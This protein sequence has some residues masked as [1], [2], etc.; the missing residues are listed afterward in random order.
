MAVYDDDFNSSDIEI[1]DVHN[2]YTSLGQDSISKLV[3]NSTKHRIT[4]KV[5]VKTLQYISGAEPTI[6][7][8][9][10]WANRFRDFCKSTL[11]HRYVYAFSREASY[12]TVK[13]RC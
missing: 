9:N 3:A 10:L 12:R 2:P 11:K 6:K 8:R 5:R 4:S 1:P 13:S 7:Q